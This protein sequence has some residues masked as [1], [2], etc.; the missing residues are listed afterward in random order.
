MRTSKCEFYLEKKLTAVLESLVS[1]TLYT[2][3]VLITVLTV[4]TCQQTIKPFG[5]ALIWYNTKMQ[6]KGLINN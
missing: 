6:M 4:A 3:L 2:V 1:H 5:Q